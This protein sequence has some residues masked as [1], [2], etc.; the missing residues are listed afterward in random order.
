MN[1]PF[2]WNTGQPSIFLTEKMKKQ[3]AAQRARD[4]KMQT[5]VAN[6]TQVK[7]KPIVPPKVP[8]EIANRCGCNHWTKKVCPAHDCPWQG[9]R[10]VDAR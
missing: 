1:S 7:H 6:G 9:K 5:E 8:A 2:N 4:K 10:P 3:A